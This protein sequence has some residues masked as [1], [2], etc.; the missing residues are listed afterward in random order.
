MIGCIFHVYYYNTFNQMCLRPD[1]GLKIIL[2]V[3]SLE[4]ITPQKII[5]FMVAILNNKMAST[6]IDYSPFYNSV[7]SVMAEDRPSILFV[8]CTVTSIECNVTR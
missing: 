3:T 1:T 7:F 8:S 2:V 5:F 6:D 4:D